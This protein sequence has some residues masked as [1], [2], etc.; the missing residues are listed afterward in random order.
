M[1]RFNMLLREAG[2][3]PTETAVLLHTPIQPGL[4]R[5]LPWIAAEEPE[6]FD[7]YQANHSDGVEKTLLGRRWVAS[8]VGTTEKRLVFVGMFEN[9]GST[10]E[11]WEAMDRLSAFQRLASIADHPSMV[12]RHAGSSRTG[13]LKF[14]LRK[15]DVLASLVG[16]VIIATPP[17][18]NYG[19]LAENLDPEVVAVRETASL[20]PDPPDWR[21]F[22]V[23]AKEVRSLPRSWKARLAEWRGIYLIVDTTD[24]ARYVGSACGAANILGRWQAHVAGDHGVTAELSKRPVE[25]F[26]FSIL[27]RTS[28]DLGARDVV[29]IENDWK[30][31]LH[32]VDHG[33]NTG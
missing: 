4:R 28:P 29:A 1:L 21:E 11:I 10:F 7:A 13:R 17:G 19:R 18:R 31:R 30:R 2:I 25:G 12:E 6:V 32:T 16:R 14:D 15:A 33:L 9:R 24:G 23:T 22:V 5:M 26:R 20:V 27:E 8:F 3:A